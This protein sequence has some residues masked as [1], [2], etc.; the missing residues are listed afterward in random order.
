MTVSDPSIPESRLR[1]FVW[2]LKVGAAAASFL[3]IYYTV[4][5]LYV[6]SDKRLDAVLSS[7]TSLTLTLILIAG[8]YFFHKG[9][10]AQ[11][12][13]FVI[14][15]LLIMI[16]SRTMFFG[17]GF[18][19]PVLYLI[20]VLI[21]FSGYILSFRNFWAITI[22]SGIAFVMLYFQASFDFWSQDLPVPTFDL[23]ILV[24]A[25]L[26]LTALATRK[27]VIELIQ[28]SQELETYQNHLEKLV[29][30][31]TAKL[32]EALEDAEK[33]NQA[34]SVFLAMMSHE[35]RTPLNA[36]IGYTEM[37]QEELSEGI[38]T[39][40]VIDDVGRIRESGKH[41]LTMINSILDLSKVEA[42]EEEIFIEVIDVCELMQSVIRASQALMTR[43]GN[44]LAYQLPEVGTLKVKADRQK[45]Y[46][47]M[48]NLIGN[49]AKFTQ[50][51]TV[52]FSVHQHR[53]ADEPFI[54]F[55]VEDTG[56]GIPEEKMPL[57]FEPFQQLDNSYNRKY[58]GSGLGLAISK[59]FCD[60]LGGHISGENRPEGGAIFKVNMPAC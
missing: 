56:I 10:Q 35:L 58:Q 49:A 32:E 26:L 37:A 1:I 5:Y 53:P 28:R 50:N 40:D 44:H 7:L 23:L 8:L 16:V 14:W 27:T 60:L 55:V 17:L 3:T 41:L 2:F 13:S 42:G 20:F 19:N 39:E 15:S 22:T 30:D 46:Q 43:S 9:Y 12:A 21:V 31:R 54:E 47:I 59:K 45:L 38:I 29:N 51:G 48:L 18:Y 52:R 6:S 24:I 25:S 4:A 34:K 33:A 11:V 36:I 57:L